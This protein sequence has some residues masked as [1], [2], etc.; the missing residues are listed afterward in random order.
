MLP[1]KSV[2]LEQKTMRIVLDTNIFVSSM[3]G[4]KLGIIIDEWRMGKFTLIVSD[5]IEQMISLLK[6]GKVLGDV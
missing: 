5:A 4:G 2:R 6:A 3:L 1:Q